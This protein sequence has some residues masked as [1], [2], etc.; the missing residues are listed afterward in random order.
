MKYEATDALRKIPMAEAI[1]KGSLDIEHY[2]IEY[3]LKLGKGRGVL[4]KSAA[5]GRGSCWRGRI[6]E[7]G[8]QGGILVSGVWSACAPRR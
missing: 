8:I 1:I 3:R 7:A 4:G 5:M 6:I 2:Q